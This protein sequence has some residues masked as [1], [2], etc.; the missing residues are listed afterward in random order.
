MAEDPSHKK[1]ISDDVAFPWILDHIFAYPA[2]YDIP[3]RTMYTINSTPQNQIL[4]ELSQQTSHHNGASRSMDES[5]YS[6][7]SSSHCSSTSQDLR[8]QQLAARTAA[9]QFKAALVSHISQLPEQ[10]CSL[11]PNMIT[12][13]VR[14]V[15][16]ANLGSVDFA[17][18]LTALD[19]L[20]DFDQRRRKEIKIAL[21][22]LSI[23]T[24]TLA[25]LDKPEAGE[26]V[27]QDEAT[28]LHANYP[29]VVQWVKSIEDRER[30]VTALY[31]QV[32]LGLR[33]WTMINEMSLRPFH[34]PNCIAMLNTLYPPVPISQPTPQLT[35]V[36]LENQRKGFFRYIQAVDR[37]GGEVLSTLI[38]Q[39]KREGEETG[40]PVVHEMVEKYLRMTNSIIDDCSEINVNHFDDGEPRERR[41]GKKTDSG[42]SFGSIKSG[43]PS[44]SSSTS[45]TH[46]K[47]KPLPAS[48]PPEQPKA[49]SVIS[50][51]S[52][53]IKRIRSRSDVKEVGDKDHKKE[54]KREKEKLKTLKKMK[55]TP[56]LPDNK[57]SHGGHSRSVSGDAAKFDPEEM[58]RTRMIWEAKNRKNS[59]AE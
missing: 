21:K 43:R 8:Q 12:N 50:K 56:N 10:P 34:K 15:Y 5:S 23:D 9:A 47:E 1:S 39:G 7:S 32:Y 36:I 58:R 54:S 26:K 44:T 19:Y 49:R 4:P 35:P 46:N 48:P 51:I 31:T 45:S 25:A 38:Q 3:L 52:Q 28:H 11:P 13:F 14:R 27:S 57:S 33:R 59:T 53:E 22:R 41:H 2:T 40:W 17:Q 42:V 29:G 37:N 24:D 6:A 18:S 55:S 30:K 16:T 20:K